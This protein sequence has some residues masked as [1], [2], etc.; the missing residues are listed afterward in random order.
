MKWD[1]LAESN[2]KVSCLF[3]TVCGFSC[4]FYGNDHIQLYFVLQYVEIHFETTFLWP[5]KVKGGKIVGSFNFCPQFNNLPTEW[6]RY[7]AFRKL[8][9]SF[10][11]LISCPRILIV[12]M[13]RSSYRPMCNTQFRNFN[14]KICKQ[15]FHNIIMTI[16][17][18]FRISYFSSFLALS[19]ITNVI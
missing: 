13:C 2:S 10:F 7:I 5:V 16:W 8:C 14:I 19:S 1:R 11:L 9:F 18:R 4:L 17:I 3:Y 12:D 15:P 6:S